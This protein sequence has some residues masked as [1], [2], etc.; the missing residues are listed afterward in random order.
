MWVLA[1]ATTITVLQRMWMVRRQT[2]G[3]QDRP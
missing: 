3:A 1:V 2:L